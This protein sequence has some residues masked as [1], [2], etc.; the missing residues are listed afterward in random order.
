MAFKKIWND[1]VWS[2]VIASVIIAALFGLGGYLWNFFNKI[3]YP[4]EAYGNFTSYL[5]ILYE[6]SPISFIG[7]TISIILI[8]YSV[9]IIFNK[10]YIVSKTIILIDRFR[11]YLM[12]KS[13]HFTDHNFLQ[14]KKP[15]TFF[16]YRITDAF[17]GLRGLH[18]VEN[19]EIA[20]KRLEIILR[21]P[22]SF[23]TKENNMLVS[24]TPIWWYR[25]LTN[26]AIRIFKPIRRKLFF[27]GKSKILL[28]QQELVIDRMAVYHDESREYLDFIYIEFKAEKPTG[29]YPYSN[30]VKERILKSRGY[31]KE[32]YGIFNGRKITREE[33]DD[34]GTIIRGKPV[35]TYNTQLRMRYIS[36]YNIIISSNES[37]YNSPK[38]D[39][40]SNKYLNEILKGAKPFDDLFEEM[41]NLKKS[42]TKY[43]Y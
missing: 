12:Q 39:E 5:K 8:S 35:R 1:P 43:R 36:R 26:S 40:I 25:G 19:S 6:K 29:L 21:N 9:I 22:L 7:Y 2:K 17:P 38:F 42:D 30:E 34:G 24:Y 20:V 18:W 13:G 28:N 41:V 37:P 23:S 11:I 15:S 16:S 27:W 32:E 14:T 10:F 31:I 33:F 3:N 4:R